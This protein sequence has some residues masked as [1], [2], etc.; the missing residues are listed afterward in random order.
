MMIA[1]PWR[2]ALTLV[3][4][5]APDEEPDEE[6]EDE[7][8]VEVTTGTTTV[9]EPKVWVD[10]ACVAVCWVA[11]AAEPDAG[12]AELGLDA[13][14]TKGFEELPPAALVRSKVVEPIVSCCG[15]LAEVSVEST[16]FPLFI[17]QIQGLLL[18]VGFMDPPLHERQLSHRTLATMLP[19]P[20]TPDPAKRVTDA[21]E[22]YF[23]SLWPT[24]DLGD[25]VTFPVP[26]A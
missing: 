14:T 5:L 1:W 17:A 22:L 20:I 12:A 7:E 24:P 26:S 9:V 2:V 25:N 23:G 21:A 4:M 19:S 10:T 3:M 13:A 6:P 18:S 8:E 11:E 15:R 16:G